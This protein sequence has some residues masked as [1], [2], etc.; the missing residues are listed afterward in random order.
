M[1]ARSVPG[2][3]TR[4]NGAARAGSTEPRLCSY[5]AAPQHI[6]SF[7]QRRT[8]AAPLSQHRPGRLAQLRRASE[9]AADQY[10]DDDDE[11]EEYGEEFEGEEE[12]DAEQDFAGEHHEAEH[13]SACNSCWMHVTAAWGMNAAAYLIYLRA[14]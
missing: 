14:S 3:K 4:W 9:P 8:L 5:R 10:A 13:S 7:L 1:L 6:V 11:F 2:L 12:V